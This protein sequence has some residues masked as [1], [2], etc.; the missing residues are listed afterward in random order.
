MEACCK[1]PTQTKY[2]LLIG[3]FSLY[4]PPGCV[5]LVGCHPSP[6]RPWARWQLQHARSLNQISIAIDTL[7]LCLS[8]SSSVHSPSGLSQYNHLSFKERAGR[9]SNPATSL[10]SLPLFN[11][12]I[13]SRVSVY[14]FHHSPPKLCP[15]IYY[16]SLQS[17]STRHLHG[18]FV[19][20]QPISGRLCVYPGTS[21][22][23]ESRPL[24]I[25]TGLV[26]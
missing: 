7:C 9:D 20:D 22:P 19:S 18:D 25:E 8:F 6:P 15:Y 16:I 4:L 26:Y 17:H 13:L 1:P 5:P 14:P 23:R 10:L 3:K 12:V 11:S 2:R 24:D 21:P